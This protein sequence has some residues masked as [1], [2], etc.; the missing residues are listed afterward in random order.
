MEKKKTK[1]VF[2]GHSEDVKTSTEGLNTLTVGAD[3]GYNDG[4][5][6]NA[7]TPTAE[8]RFMCVR[9]CYGKQSSKNDYGRND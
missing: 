6:M 8:A 9:R 1:S 5:W 2:L 7:T 3:S 4:H